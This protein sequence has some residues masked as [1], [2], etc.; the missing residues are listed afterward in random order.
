MAEFEVKCDA[1]GKEVGA[2]FYLSGRNIYL[3]VDP[4]ETCLEKAKAEGYKQKED[5]G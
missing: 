1:C 2:D 3:N 4:C 5:E